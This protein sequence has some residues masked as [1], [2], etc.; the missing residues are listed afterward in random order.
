MP[1]QFKMKFDAI[2]SGSQLENEQHPAAEF[3]GGVGSAYK[4]P[5]KLNYK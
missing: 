4:V 3:E 1:A 5:E 2:E